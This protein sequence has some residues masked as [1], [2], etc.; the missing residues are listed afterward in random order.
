MDHPGFRGK[1]GQGLAAVCGQPA[2]PLGLRQHLVYRWVSRHW[3]AA[4][5]KLLICYR[6]HISSTICKHYQPFLNIFYFGFLI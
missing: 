5:I 2:P 1:V 6:S 3:T 4:Y